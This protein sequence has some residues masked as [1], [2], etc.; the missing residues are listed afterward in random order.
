[1]TADE[2][3][4]VV[5]AAA[6]NELGSALLRIKHCLGQLN[7]EQVWHRSQPGLNSIGNLILHLCGN[8]RQWVIAGLGGAS[9]GR[10]RPAEFAERGPSRRRSCCA[11]SKPSSK[12]RSASWLASR[13]GSL[14]RSDAFRGST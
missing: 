12:K 4:V 13:P 9:D 1:M 3:A 5:G 10:N 14:W 11:G 6:A 8:M 7:D 2:L